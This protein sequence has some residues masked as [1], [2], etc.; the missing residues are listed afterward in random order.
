MV[1]QRHNQ[2]I[3]DDVP[4]SDSITAYDEAHLVVYL[5]LLDATADGA[6]KNEMAEVILGIDPAKEP[7]RA[8]RVVDSHLRRA[9]W[10]SRV[11]YRHLLRG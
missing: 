11:G 4:W 6:S 3:A 7:Q 8:E 5:R 2:P 1:A 9:R 10:M